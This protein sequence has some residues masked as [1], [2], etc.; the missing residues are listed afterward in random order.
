M[1]RHASWI[2]HPKNKL[3]EPVCFEKSIKIEKKIRR[4][5]LHI[6]S[7]GCYY[8]TINGKRVGDFILAPGFT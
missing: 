8:A 5:Y 7:L 4:A 2:I 6:T 3:Y 1:F